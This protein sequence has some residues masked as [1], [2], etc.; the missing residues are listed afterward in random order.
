MQVYALDLL[1][2]GAS[3]KPNLEEGYSMEVRTAVDSGG[4]AGWNTH[5]TAEGMHAAQRSSALHACSAINGDV[6]VC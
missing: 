2:F 5:A 6:S 3:A 1:G 4:C